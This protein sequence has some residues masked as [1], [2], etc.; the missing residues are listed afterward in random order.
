[1]T[2]DAG[3]AGVVVAS[4][5]SECVHDCTIQGA[6]LCVVGVPLWLLKYIINEILHRKGRKGR[7]VTVTMSLRSLR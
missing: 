3:A 2:T 1:M 7:K 5:A 4:S 6:G